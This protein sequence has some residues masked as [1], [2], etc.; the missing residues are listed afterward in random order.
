MSSKKSKKEL[1]QN[2]WKTISGEVKYDNPWIEVT[3]FKV[4]NAAG[5]EGIYGKVHF[6]NLAIGIIPMDKNGN[7]WLVGQYRYP[8]DEYSWEIPEGG[9]KIG[10]EPLDSAKRELLEET[11]LIA[12]EWQ[13]IQR[14]HL[15]N[16]V[17]DELGI[18]YLATDLEQKEAEPEEDEVLQIIK[19][20]FTEAFE[21][22]MKGE[23]TDS[24]TVAGILK[25]KVLK[26]T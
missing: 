25:L 8:L 21:M 4:I 6:K 9:G 7:I 2:P 5:N 23:I 19:V 12:N 13:E 18:I 10:V 16:S 1:E 3:E 26:F 15:S 11:G 14:L 17:S 22:V 24:L 20:P